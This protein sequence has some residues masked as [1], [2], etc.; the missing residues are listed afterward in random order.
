MPDITS[1]HNPRI[2]AAARLRDRRH[3]DKQQRL[4]IDGARELRRALQ[5]EVRI[6]EVF[7]CD[8]LCSSADGQA[9]VAAVVETAAEL[10]HVT[11][12]VYRKLAFGQRHDGLVAVAET[13][14]RQLA[15]LTLAAGPL[16]GVLETVEKPGNVGA[17]VRSADGAGLSALIVADA[18]TDLFNPNAIRASLGTIFSLPVCTANAAAT[19]AWLRAQRLQI[20]AA[21]VDGSIPYTQADYRGPCALVLGS[22]ASGLST[23]WQ[24]DDVTAIRLPMCGTADSL[25]VSAAAAVLFYEALRQRHT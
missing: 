23:I 7:V 18:G 19:L 24:A 25:N 5:A 8:S 2:N 13:P 17:V 9:V 22:E 1:V 15:D 10:F 3:R 20:F 6:R 16:V 14:R 11:E 4:L 12:N 21:R